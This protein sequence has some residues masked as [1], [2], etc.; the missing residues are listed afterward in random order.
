MYFFTLGQLM[1][2]ADWLVINSQAIDALYLRH[3]SSWFL[4]TKI[5]FFF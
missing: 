5:Q 2:Q 1:S 3:E 4:A